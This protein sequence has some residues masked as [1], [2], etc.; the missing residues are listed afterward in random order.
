MKK[1]LSIL[2]LLFFSLLAVGQS[3]FKITTANLNL[4]YGP[5]T[6]NEIIKV[7]PKNSKVTVYDTEL[8]TN[9]W[10][11]VSYNGTLGFVYKKYLATPQTVQYSSETKSSGNNL[12]TSVKYYINSFGQKVQSPTYY[13]TRPAGATAI[14][15]DGTYSFSRS[16]R[17][18]C[19]GHGGVRT[20]L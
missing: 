14:C 18:T 1:F 8:N 3:Q 17:G 16:R 7:I 5:S 12:S 11:V 15:R 2:F 4:R 19:S 20:W 6:S 9:N 10:Y 13:D